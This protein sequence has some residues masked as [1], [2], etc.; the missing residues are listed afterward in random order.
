MEHVNHHEFFDHNR[1]RDMFRCGSQEI[2]ENVSRYLK[3]NLKKYENF[4]KSF[5]VFQ[6]FPPVHGNEN[7]QHRGVRHFVDEHFQ[8][9][10]RDRE[11]RPARWT[12]FR[13]RPDFPT[14]RRRN[15]ENARPARRGYTAINIIRLDRAILRRDEPA[16]QT[17]G[18]TTCSR[19]G[20]RVL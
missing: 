12:V 6:H 1:W 18:D 8:Y 11:T 16:Y 9:S 14:A 15:G 5:P 20:K 7:S 2:F 13:L 10:R 4:Q 19:P 17:N 3:N